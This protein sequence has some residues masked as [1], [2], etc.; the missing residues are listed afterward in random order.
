MLDLSLPDVDPTDVRW[1]DDALC[2]Q[3]DPELFHPEKGGSPKAA[4]RVCLACDVRAQCLAW[5]IANDEQDGV[6]GGL[7]RAERA[8]LKRAAKAAA[9]SDAEPQP[10]PADPAAA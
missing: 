3:T 6:W 4:K 8:K 1:L 7:S 9:E 10:E 2:A 5:A